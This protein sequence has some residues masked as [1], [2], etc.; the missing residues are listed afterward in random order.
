VKDQ[1]EYMR[2][3]FNEID[4]NILVLLGARAQLSKRIAKLKNNQQI[5]VKQEA[6]WK[7]NLADRI[8]ENVNIKID[9]EYLKKIFEVIHEE[10]IRI[11]QSE[12]EKL[13]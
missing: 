5:D 7:Q 10:S 3:Q 8:K 4:K 11:Q 13:K 6:V 1:L 2:Y 9:S 12:I